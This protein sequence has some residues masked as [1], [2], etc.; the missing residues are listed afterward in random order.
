VKRSWLLDWKGYFGPDKKYGIGLLT[1][2]LEA[3]HYGCPSR[4]AME[5]HGQ[6]VWTLG[7]AFGG[8]ILCPAKGSNF[9]FLLTI[10]SPFC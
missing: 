1:W 6:K 10:F 7:L 2:P 8:F 3:S 9:Y 4:E 5:V